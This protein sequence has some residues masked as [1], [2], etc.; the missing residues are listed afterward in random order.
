[1]EGQEG[2]TGEINLILV[3]L[4]KDAGFTVNPL[5]VRFV[6]W[7]SYCVADNQLIKYLLR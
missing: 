3:N 6:Q 4:L 1:M 2:T 5:L 7:N